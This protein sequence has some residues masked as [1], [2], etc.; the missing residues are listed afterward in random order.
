MGGD[1]GLQGAAGR[2]GDAVEQEVQQDEPRHEVGVAKEARHCKHDARHDLA[3]NHDPFAPH[4][5]GQLAA[6]E[7]AGH[8]SQSGQRHERPGCAIGKT[9]ALGEQQHKEREDK[10][11]DPIDDGSDEQDVDCCR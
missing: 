3:E 7:G 5:V 2:V 6:D 4:A 1:I 8:I 11:P 9:E 10:A